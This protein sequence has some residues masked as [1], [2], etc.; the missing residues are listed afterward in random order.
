MPDK[1][2]DLDKKTEEKAV[3]PSSTEVPLTLDAGPAPGK[4]R[5]LWSDAWHDLRRSPLFIVSALL[6]L[7]LIVM[8]IWPSLFTDASPRDAD[9]KNHF[10]QH[11]NWGNLFAADWFGYD[12]QGRSIYARVVYGARASISV[13][14]VVTLAVTIVGTIVGMVAGFFGGWV[15]SL[16]SRLTDVFFGVPFIVGAMVIL[17]TFEERAVWVVILALA[18]LGWTQIA[19]VA[20]GAVI[21]IKQSD[22]VVAA[23]ALGA[24]T[25]RI[26]FKHILPN[27]MAPIIVVATI[28]LGGYIGAEATLSYLGIGLAEPTVSW[29]IDVSAGKDQ[30]RNAPYVLMIPSVM[31]AITV[32]SFLMFGDAV[33]NALDPKMR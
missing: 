12:G 23:R 9:L 5:S 29:G 24:S 10:L 30:L 28:A 14:I 15:D 18:F 32:L 17:T 3:M 6:I 11:P 2:A 16:L 25:S 27:A 20:R 1:T 4:P 7:F 33:R 22:Y 13:G 21:T 31:V 26:M 19:R 8:A